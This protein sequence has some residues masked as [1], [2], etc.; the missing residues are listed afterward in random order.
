MVSAL[1]GTAILVVKADK[2]EVVCSTL[3]AVAEVDWIVVDMAV[4]VA[5]GVLTLL[6]DRLVVIVSTVL[7]GADVLSTDT[8]GLALVKAGD[9]VCALGLRGDVVVCTL[10][11]M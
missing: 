9:V 8:L 7:V 1:V 10:P 3:D 2:R 4:V 6:V 5:C 11:V